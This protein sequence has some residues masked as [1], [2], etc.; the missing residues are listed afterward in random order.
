M[1]QPT[2]MPLSPFE[3]LPGEVLHEITYLSL[4]LDLCLVSKELRKNINIPYTRTKVL[5]RLSDSLVL[6][7]IK[8]GDIYE[9][10][11]TITSGKERQVTEHR[12]KINSIN[13][14]HYDPEEIRAFAMAL[15]SSSFT[16]IVLNKLRKIRSTKI[17][18]NE[19]EDV[20]IYLPCIGKI[21]L[22]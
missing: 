9:Q 5:D 12:A 20:E 21:A 6:K 7:S 11:T 1:A 8:T 18:D 17:G 22:L 14:V 3:K 15:Q 4:N 13:A 19:M 2:T 10:F 16:F